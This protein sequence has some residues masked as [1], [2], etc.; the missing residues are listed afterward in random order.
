[1]IVKNFF[2]AL[3]G[4]TGSGRGKMGRAQCKVAFLASLFGWV[5]K[6]FRWCTMLIGPQM[7]RSHQTPNPLTLLKCH[8]RI[9]FTEPFSVCS[10]SRKQSVSLSRVATAQRT[11]WKDSHS[12]TSQISDSSGGS[13]LSCR[14]SANTCSEWTLLKVR[15]LTN[16]ISIRGNISRSW[17]WLMET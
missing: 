12:C 17:G 6:V 3:W 11:W 5:N 13:F 14:R 7:A 15:R 1:M 9:S 10:T 8:A 16:F 4:K 2:G